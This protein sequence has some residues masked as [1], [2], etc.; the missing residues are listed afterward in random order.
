MEDEGNYRCMVE[1]QHTDAT[2]TVERK[3]YFYSLSRMNGK[4]YFV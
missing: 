3:F 4:E 1:N 2:L